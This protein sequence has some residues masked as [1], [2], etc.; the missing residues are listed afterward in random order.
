MKMYRKR[1]P[2][3][4]AMLFTGSEDSALNAHQYF[5]GRLVKFDYK[6]E[7]IKKG[8][9]LLVLTEQGL[10]ICPPNK[11]ILQEGMFIKVYSPEDFKEKYNEC[12]DV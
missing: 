3:V 4:P 9:R 2:V 12:E 1:E 11:Y 8:L 7:S 6:K 5:G 10:A